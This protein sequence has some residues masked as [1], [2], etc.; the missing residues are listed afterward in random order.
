MSTLHVTQRDSIMVV[1][2]VYLR[3]HK[4]SYAVMIYSTMVVYS[5]TKVRFIYHYVGS[6]LE[7]LRGKKLITKHTFIVQHRDKL[8]IYEYSKLCGIQ[9]IYEQHEIERWSYFRIILSTKN[10]SKHFFFKFPLLNSF[11]FKYGVNIISFLSKLIYLMLINYSIFFFYLKRPNFLLHLPH[12]YM[13]A[14]FF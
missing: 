12:L 5:M 10:I 4:Q 14:F 6:K 9:T 3:L 11:A 2:L 8:V 7:I 13:L 1:C